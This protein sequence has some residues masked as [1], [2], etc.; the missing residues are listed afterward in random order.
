MG[1]LD[2]GDPVLGK[3]CP[4]CRVEAVVYNGNYFCTYCG[5]SMHE[6][7]PEHGIV[8]AY[9]IQRLKAAQEKNDAEEIAAM[10][11]HLID[12]G[13]VKDGETV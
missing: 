13:Y 5:W 1:F 6:G 12:G 11:F 2:S 10:S 3:K 8:K 7:G 9:L 4:G